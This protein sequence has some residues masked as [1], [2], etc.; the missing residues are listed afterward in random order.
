[1]PNLSPIF[2]AHSKILEEEALKEKDPYARANLTIKSHK[3]KIVA[4]EMESKLLFVVGIMFFLLFLVPV[5]LWMT[6]DICL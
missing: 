2:R 6:Y 5:I 3:A 4:L 1:M